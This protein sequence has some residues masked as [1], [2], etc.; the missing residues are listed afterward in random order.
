M[1]S[2]EF[3]LISSLCGFA[4]PLHF[5]DDEDM[6]VNLKIRSSTWNFNATSKDF[7]LPIQII[8]AREK[9]MNQIIDLRGG[10]W[11]GS[12][13]MKKLKQRL[14]KLQMGRIRRDK[15][16]V[17]DWYSFNH[18]ISVEI[19]IDEICNPIDTYHWEPY[20]IDSIRKY[21]STGEI[22]ITEKMLNEGYDVLLAFSCLGIIC[23]TKL[24]TF[25]SFATSL[26]FS[27]WRIYHKSRKNI[28]DWVE[29]EMVGIQSTEQFRRKIAFVTSP[30]KDGFNVFLADLDIKC[31]VLDMNA[32]E[33]MNH[34]G[35][36]FAS[37]QT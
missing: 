24:V 19:D 2:F 36:F 31:T 30:K 21:Y 25:D 35:E 37:N 6:L 13:I 23:D 29:K 12:F 15:A 7:S 5:S 27:T 3:P 14:S 26:R 17:E 8:T 33:E 34:E 9:Q 20:L 4:H 32:S 16:W 18:Q 11:K 1:I 28:A 10:R 22:S